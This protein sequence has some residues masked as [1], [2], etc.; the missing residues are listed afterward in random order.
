MRKPLWAACLHIVTDNT[1]SLLS[2]KHTHLN[3]TIMNSPVLHGYKGLSERETPQHQTYVCQRFD[4][5]HTHA[6][7]VMGQHSQVWFDLMSFLDSCHIVLQSSW[8][9]K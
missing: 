5:A 8:S 3:I 1:V 2:E 7:G 9:L 4:G 6:S